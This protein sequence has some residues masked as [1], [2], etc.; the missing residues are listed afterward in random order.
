[1]VP[2]SVK[3]LFL[4]VGTAA[5]TVSVVVSVNRVNFIIDSV[6]TEGEVVEMVA[7]QSSNTSRSSSVSYA[8]CILFTDIHGRQIEFVSSI[9]G[10]RG[11]YEI[12]EKVDVIYDP[13]LPEEARLNGFFTVWGVATVTGLGGAAFFSIGFVL[14]FS[15]MRKKSIHAHL[16][17][18]GIRITPDYLWVE[19][20]DMYS[21]NGQNPYQ[22][23]AQWKDPANSKEHLFKSENIWF[24]PSEFIG[25]ESITV[26]IDFNKPKRYLVD[27]PFLK[28]R[29]NCPDYNDLNATK[30]QG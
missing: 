23:L 14:L 1:M 2:K 28:G 8:P 16:R 15:G 13:E 17:R 19:L 27:L 25:K 12:G 9:S 20:N 22:I 11:F 30:S 5:L 26:L 10:S 21:V 29:E 18:N 4:L 6:K 24:N 7:R 3:Y